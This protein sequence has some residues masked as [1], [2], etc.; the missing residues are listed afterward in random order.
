MFR[1]FSP[2]RDIEQDT[3]F[4]P[5]N[6]QS[7]ASNIVADYNR[8]GFI[9]MMNREVINASPFREI[10]M[11]T[12]LDALIDMVRFSEVRIFASFDISCFS[13]PAA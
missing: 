5:E 11:R 12:L 10:F 9:T 6:F 7:I 13:A 8:I 3:P 2:R 4:I 1:L